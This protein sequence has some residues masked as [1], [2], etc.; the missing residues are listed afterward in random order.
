MCHKILIILKAKN[1]TIKKYTENRTSSLNE[2][3]YVWILFPYPNFAKIAILGDF[4]KYI[5]ALNIS[6]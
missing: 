5:L 4:L 1:P 6:Q 2:L 3:K